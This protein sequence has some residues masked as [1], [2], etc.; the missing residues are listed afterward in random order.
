MTIIVPHR[1]TAAKAV[2]MVDRSATT[3]FEGVGGS[4]VELVD[5]K[6]N[7]KGQVMDFSLTARVGFI[8]V[9]I[10]GTVVVDDV[11]VTVQCQLP[12]LVNQ[13]I[14]EDKIRASVDSKIRGMLGTSG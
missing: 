14:G 7:W 6:K 11:N 9:P 2:A 4:P 5:R 13:F 3:L 1:T 10:S 12:G 8:S